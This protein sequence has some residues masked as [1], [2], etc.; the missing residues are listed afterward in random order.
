MKLV[1]I[2]LQN[3]SDAYDTFAAQLTSLSRKL[4]SYEAYTK[5]FPSSK[6][7]QNTLALVY[8]DYLDFCV[9]AANHFERNGVSE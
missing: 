7:L 9:R 4:P 3:N 8:T 5:L 1:L 2:L 6:M